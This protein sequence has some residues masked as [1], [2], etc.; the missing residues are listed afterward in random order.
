MIA[1]PAKRFG[2]SMISSV[3]NQRKLR[4]MVYDGA[5]KAATFIVFLRRLVKD[6][7]RRLFVIV[8]NLPVHRANAVAAWVAAHAARIKLFHL[9]PYAPERNP[10]SSST[11]MSSRRGAGSARQ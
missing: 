1:R 7:N 8:N 9:P 5:L 3:T 6:T 4:F 10:T 2:Q 11:M